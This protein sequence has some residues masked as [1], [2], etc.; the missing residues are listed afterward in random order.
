[1]SFF[2]LL[3]NCNSIKLDGFLTVLFT[4]PSNEFLYHAAE[5]DKLNGMIHQLSSTL[6]GVKHEQEYMEV[7]DRVH[8]ASKC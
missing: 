7:R 6:I 8:R 1:M 2:F 5:H 4:Q 3:S